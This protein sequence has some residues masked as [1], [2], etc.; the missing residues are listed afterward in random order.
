MRLVLKLENNESKFQTSVKRSSANPVFEEVFEFN[1]ATFQ[2]EC[3]KLFIYVYSKRLL[4][5]KNLIGCILYGK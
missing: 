4:S 1:L 3:A 2:V 5:N